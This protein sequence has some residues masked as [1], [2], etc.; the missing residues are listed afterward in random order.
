MIGCV[1]I[2]W[3]LQI[4]PVVTL[5]LHLL[6]RT[7]IMFLGKQLVTII[8]DVDG[9]WHEVHRF[10]VERIGVVVVAVVVV[11]VVVAWKDVL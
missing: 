2:N 9:R 6:Q 5:P 8:T 10:Y 11:A 1:D 3:Y 4:P 7:M